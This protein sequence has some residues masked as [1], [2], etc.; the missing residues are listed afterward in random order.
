MSKGLMSDFRVKNKY[1][2]ILLLRKLHALLI[3]LIVVIMANI[4]YIGFLAQK[5][6]YT[7]VLRISQTSLS[8]FLLNSNHSPCKFEILNFLCKRYSNLDAMSIFKLIIRVISNGFAFTKE[9][10]RFFKFLVIPI[11]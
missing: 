9:A 8:W 1:I 11:L 10:N 5:R 7:G 2:F 6:A 4:N 3:L